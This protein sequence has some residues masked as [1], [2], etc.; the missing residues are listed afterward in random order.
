MSSLDRD[1]TKN[2][3]KNQAQAYVLLELP[4][5]TQQCTANIEHVCVD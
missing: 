2:G 5:S 4:A 3:E 1:T